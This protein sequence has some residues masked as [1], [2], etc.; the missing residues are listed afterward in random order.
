M[1]VDGRHAI[2]P[3]V[4]LSDIGLDGAEGSVQLDNG[5]AVLRVE[6]GSVV[7]NSASRAGPYVSTSIG[8]GEPIMLCDGDTVSGAT[9]VATFQQM[10]ADSPRKEKRTLRPTTNQISQT[11]EP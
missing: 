6:S 11:A 10:P 4:S 3:R 8:P 5:D 1:R 9:K 2:K 7:V